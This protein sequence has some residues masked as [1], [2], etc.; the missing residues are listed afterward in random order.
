M[1]VTSRDCAVCSSGFP[2][3]CMDGPGDIPA[4]CAVTRDACTHEVVAWQN[5]L[6][7]TPTCSG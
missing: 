5:R 6:R 7:L 2:A 4:A 3:D 1:G